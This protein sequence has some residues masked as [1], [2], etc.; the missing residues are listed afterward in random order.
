MDVSPR[1]S[2]AFRSRPASRRQQSDLVTLGQKV[3]FAK[4]RERPMSAIHR[5]HRYCT[6]DEVDL[7]SCDSNGCFCDNKRSEK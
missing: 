3:Y 6:A 4:S 1:G 2:R 7:G 5:C